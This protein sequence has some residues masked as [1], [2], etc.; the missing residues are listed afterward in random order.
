M[1]T[2]SPS[3]MKNALGLTRSGDLAGATRL[4]QQMLTGKVQA[5]AEPAADHVFPME[6]LSWPKASRNKG[7]AT[8]LR[9]AT[10]TQIKH[11]YKSASG[12]IAYELYVPSKVTG[13]MP[14]II[15]LHGCTQSAQ[16]FAAGTRMNKLADEFGFAVA[17]P[18]QPASA[19][20]QRCWN[21]F[22]PGDQ[23]R[24]G[25]EPALIAG[26]TREIIA[27]RPVNAAQVYIAGL[28]AGGA[29]AANMAAA[30]PDLYAAVGIHSGLACGVAHDMPSAFAAMNGGAAVIPIGDQPFVPTITF[31]GGSDNTV[32]HINSAQIHSRNQKHGR[33]AGADRITD[34]GK[35]AAGQRFVKE[36]LVDETGRSLSESWTIP[37]AG[38]A[39]SGGSS[40]GTWT[41]P[42]G[43]DASR[44]MVRFFL[45]HSLQQ[46][47][48]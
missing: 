25:G 39:W 28:S 29:A 47:R 5:S 1:T 4:I 34:H 46:G 15:M 26:L 48:Y 43:A 44:E 20:A 2:I 19:N 21:W 45:Q 6:S 27:A 41:D 22:R 16:D 37:D 42:T 30:Y 11:T 32:K 24:D 12:S 3:G 8:P 35:S 36:A 23:N 33:L 17:Y 10:S 14:L 38:H 18:E 40:S 13:D 7:T 9:S 31:H